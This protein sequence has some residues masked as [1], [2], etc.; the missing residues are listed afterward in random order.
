MD[1]KTLRK[2]YLDIRKN[3]PDKDIKSAIIFDKVINTQ[4]Y[5][6]SH[7]IALYKN[8]ESEVNTDKLITYSISIGKIVLLPKVVGND[9]V[10]YQITKETI[11][12]KSNFGVYEPME[13]DNYDGNID[14]IIVPGICFDK[15]N[16]RLGFGKGYY[17]KYLTN[18]NL[19]KMG[20]C[21]KEQLVESIPTDD[22][23]I[24]MDLIITD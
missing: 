18:N 6:H 11:F 24:K 3:L 23:D 9:M 22:N 2:R 14:L 17:D 16:N 8:L 1:K 19:K 20:I 21:F 7:I 12:L 10:F 4:E 5:Q 13:K 15:N